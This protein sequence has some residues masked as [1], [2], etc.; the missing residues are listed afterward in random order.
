[1]SDLMLRNVRER[2][3]REGIAPRHVNRYVTELR[4]HLTDLIHR[5]CG[6]GVDRPAGEA[7]ARSILGTESQLVQAMLDRDPPRS[8]AAKAPWMTFGILPILALLALLMLLGTASM[9]WFAPYR[10]IPLAEMPASIRALRVL[11]TALGSYGI[12]LILALGC[13]VVAVRQRLTSGWMWAGLALVAA[14]SGALGLHVE[15]INAAG[16]I[17][18]SL[19]QS[20]SHNG[21]LDIGAT[22]LLV[23]ARAL[24]LLAIATL[25][26]RLLRQRIERSVT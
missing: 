18:G 10:D 9:A 21:H 4:D 20:V 17:H 26:L 2:L 5:E 14:I 1:M 12:S 8:M 23:S 24:G 13:V 19:T 25:T 6:T 11:V 16:G 3:L 15:F 7:R 22:A